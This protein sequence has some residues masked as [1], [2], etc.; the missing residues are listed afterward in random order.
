MLQIE[1]HD[2]QVSPFYCPLE[3]RLSTVPTQYI[4]HAG[5]VH[6]THAHNKVALYYMSW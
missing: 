6:S 2:P 4:M 5:H 3:S 1:G